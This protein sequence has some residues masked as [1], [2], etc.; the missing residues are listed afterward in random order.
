M[1]SLIAE[2]EVL[3]VSQ[4][5]FYI[6]EMFKDNKSLSNIFLMGEVSNLVLYNKSGHTYFSLKDEQSS[7]KAVIFAGVAK[8]LKFLP[9]DGLKVI[10][11]GDICVFE[12]NG[13]YQIYVNYIEPAGIGALNLAFQQLKIKLEKA[14]IFSKEYKKTLPLY[15]KRIGV[16]TSSTGA[17]LWDIQTTLKKRAPIIEI[18]FLPVMVQGSKASVEI[19]NAL[20]FFNKING[21]DALIIARGGG[22]LEDLWPFNNE[23]L[24]Y[25]VFKSSIPV[26][27]A[28]GH[29]TDFTICDFASD[30]RAATPTAAAELISIGYV[31]A[32]DRLTSYFYSIN[33]SLREK[34]LLQKYKLEK[35]KRNLEIKNPVNV[36]KEKI[37]KLEM[38][39]SRLSNI[40][41]KVL[42]K[43]KNKLIELKTK[44]ESF[45][46]QKI[47]SIGYALV[48]SSKNKSIKSVNDVKLNDKLNVKFLDG[49]AK[50][51]VTDIVKES[52]I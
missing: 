40:L 46:P 7:I 33:K 21:I 39:H 18:Y 6:K 14:G 9:R 2:G 26:I 29:E 32:R 49:T 44:L 34:L 31:N 16:I 5:N 47:F 41:E 45:N 13:T 4:I 1:D 28:V 8:K 17:V 23:D 42:N 48:L 22:S 11:R 50:C 25:A 15:P 30:K 37:H 24:A 12:T 3:T 19:I 27:S 38:Y 43:N 52:L 36:L 10:V 20:S 35:L 51:D